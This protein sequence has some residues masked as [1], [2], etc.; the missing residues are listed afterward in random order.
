MKYE[1]IAKHF[2]DGLAEG[3]FLGLKCTECGNIE[4]PPYPAC[5]RCGHIGNEWVDIRDA[6]VIVD[7]IYSISPMMT[8]GDFIP[9][10]PLFNCEAHIEEGNI[11]FTCLLFGVTKKNYKQIRE[12]VPLHAKLVVLPMDNFNS[13]ALSLDGTL[14]ERKGSAGVMDSA[15]AIAAMGTDRMKEKKEDNGIDGNYK[16]VAKVMGQK[17][18]CKISVYVD[19]N[20]A[21]G[22]LEVMDQLMNYEGTFEN[23]KL[24]FTTPARGSEFVFDGTVGNGNIEGSMKFGVFKMAVSGERM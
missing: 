7:E 12:Q 21:T 9:Y 18:N 8:A 1:P 16:C 11:E 24:A 2:Y 23:G 20:K 17:R 15:A 3:K 22:T 6:D 13:F 14:P 10:A 19:G 4:F 5:N